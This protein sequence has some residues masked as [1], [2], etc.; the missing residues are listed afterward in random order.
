MFEAVTLNEV[1]DILKSFAKDKSPGPDGWTMELFLAFFDIMGKDLLEVIED[2][3]V[4]GYVL[5]AI[6]STFITLIPK[7]DKP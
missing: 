6:N 5:G 7:K 2:S 3:R 4:N 1:E